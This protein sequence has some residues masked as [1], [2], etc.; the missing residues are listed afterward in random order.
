MGLKCENLL[1]LGSHLCCDNIHERY[2]IVH[3]VIV[4]YVIVH[5]VI[6]HDVTKSIYVILLL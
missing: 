5:D 6:V 4:Y 3:D 2:P 1:V